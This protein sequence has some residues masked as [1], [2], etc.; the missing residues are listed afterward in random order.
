MVKGFLVVNEAKNFNIDA[1][2][3]QHAL[4]QAHKAY[5]KN[6]VPIWYDI[7]SVLTFLALLISPLLGRRLRR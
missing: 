7:I 3:M 5:D 6:E 4:K 2:A 1:F